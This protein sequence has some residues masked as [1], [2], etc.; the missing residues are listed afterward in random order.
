M[1]AP[2]RTEEPAVEAATDRQGAVDHRKPHVRN[3]SLRNV[4][5]SPVAAF[6][7]TE[8]AGGAVTVAELEVKA[9]AAELIGDRQTITDSGKFKIEL[10]ASKLES[11]FGRNVPEVGNSGLRINLAQPRQT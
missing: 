8:L 2:I 6:L 1:N 4:Q 3:R 11:V 10:M 5:A 9:R 7:Q